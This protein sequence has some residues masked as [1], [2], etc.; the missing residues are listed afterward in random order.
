MASMNKRKSKYMRNIGIDK[1]DYEN[2]DF[3]YGSDVLTTFILKA[4][5]K[6]CHSRLFTEF[7]LFDPVEDFRCIRGDL[8]PDNFIGD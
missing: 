6:A 4:I 3:R 2:F 1:L 5:N 7:V 8:H